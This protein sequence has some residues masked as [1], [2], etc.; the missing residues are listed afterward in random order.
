MRFFI[1]DFLKSS[2]KIL[3]SVIFIV[4]TIFHQPR[5]LQ[6]QFTGLLDHLFYL[7]YIFM[8]SFGILLVYASLFKIIKYSLTEIIF[9]KLLYYF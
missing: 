2:K 1:F 5:R 9:F 3:K 8:F 4:W 7:L 6:K